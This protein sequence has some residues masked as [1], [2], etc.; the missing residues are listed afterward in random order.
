MADTLTFVR[1]YDEAGTVRTFVFEQADLEWLPG[2]YQ[3]YTL[4]QAGET[5][6]EHSRF[7]TIASA[8]SEH[9]IH[10]STRVTDSTFKQALNQLQPGDTIMRKD[11]EG[12]FTWDDESDTPVVLVAAGIGSTPYR[13]M[14]LERHATGKPL[15][16]TVLYYTRDDQIPFKAEFD[17]LVEQHDE[18]TIHY[19]VGQPVTTESILQY[20][21]QATNQVT[22]I[23][24]PE[25]MVDAIGDEL[26]ARGVDLKQDWFPGYDQTTF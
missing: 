18:L 3:F 23:S 15:A 14:L 20:A 26:K 1:S 5:E 21:P 24:G 7:F 16:A 2:Q 25:P 11:L 12:D 22:Y 6:E 13:S 8:P 10:I 19:I 4:P 17:A 9:E